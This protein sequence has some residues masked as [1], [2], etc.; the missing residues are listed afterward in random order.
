MSKGVNREKL[1]IAENAS[2]GIFH[3][4]ADTLCLEALVSTEDGVLQCLSLQPPCIT[5]LTHRHWSQWTDMTA[6]SDAQSPFGGSPTGLCCHC[7]LWDLSG[8]M[9]VGEIS[10]ATLPNPATKQSWKV[11]VAIC[12]GGSTQPL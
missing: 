7:A 2:V 1:I 6:V 11:K 3:L 8:Q 5:F 9:E 12:P 4:I 10:P